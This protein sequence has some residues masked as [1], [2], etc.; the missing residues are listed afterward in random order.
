MDTKN[1]WSELVFEDNENFDNESVLDLLRE[2][3]QKL[4]CLTKGRLKLYIEEEE[5]CFEFNKDYHKTVIVYIVSLR[6]SIKK[7]VLNEMINNSIFT[8]VEDKD[9]G[10]FPV[11]IYC[12]MLYEEYKHISKDEFLDKITTLL[13]NPV[14][15]KLIQNMYKKA[16]ADLSYKELNKKHFLNNE[17]K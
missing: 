2:Q 3:G 7:D 8:I 6:A 1:I 14:I 11:D 9:K 16:E 10:R 5:K 12:K 13:N 17:D 15:S 4:A